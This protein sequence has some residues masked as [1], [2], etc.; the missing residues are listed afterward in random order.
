ME[1]KYNELDK[2]EQ[3][4]DGELSKE[5]LE[6]AL[7]DKDVQEETQFFQAMTEVLAE[8]GKSQIKELLA[9]VAIE[10][11]NPNLRAKLAAQ[12]ERLSAPK[13]AK[14]RQIRPM[15]RILAIAASILV[16]VV[17]GTLWF[18]NRSPSA[19]LLAEQNYIVAD[20][21]GTMGGGVAEDEVF[22][23][24]LNVFA[25]EDWQVAQT[26]LEEIPSTSAKYSEAQYFLGHIHFQQENFET[27]ISNYQ[28]ALAAENLPN[29]INRDKLNWNLLLAKL[30]AGENIGDEL[31]ELIETANPPIDRMAREL[32]EELK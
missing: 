3:F 19:T 29:Y 24:A 28:T 15:R 13:E 16:L 23:Q 20:L 12:N 4:F 18:L 8:D 27:A 31:D 25:A 10:N 17:A 2:I 14:V 5:E 1:D 26:A 32:K 6:H 11:V 30:G 7:K 21:P 22:Q 9:D